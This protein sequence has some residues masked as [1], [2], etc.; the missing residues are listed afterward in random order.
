[1]LLS[2]TTPG[3]LALAVA[4]L[5]EAGGSTTSTRTQT[6][7]LPQRST[8]SASNIYAS[9]ITETSSTTQYLLAC[10]T[11]FSASYTCDG[12]FH[13]VT[14]TYGASDI[15]VAF[16]ATTYDCEYGKSA[17]CETRTASSASDST[18]TLNSQQISSWM[19]AITII[20]AGK[21]AKTTKS[22]ST[23]TDQ[24]PAA[25]TEGDSSGLC[26]RKTTHNSDD[27][28][29]SDSSDSSNGGGSG[30]GSSNGKSKKGGDGCSEGVT[31]TWTG[32]AALFLGAGLLLGILG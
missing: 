1:M 6:I 25:T 24:A 5:T 9:I 16:D 18:I 30:S 26:K 23:K 21:K 4:A 8:G 19:T 11:D 31:I 14:L 20:D 10:Q 17:V 22:S 12:D 29:D 32:G 7:F 13:G 27:G 3:L 28:G 15:D 2:T